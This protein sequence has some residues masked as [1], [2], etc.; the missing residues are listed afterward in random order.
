[1]PASSHGGRGLFDD[2]ILN[3]EVDIGLVCALVG[4]ICG[5]AGIAAIL[6]YAVPAC[7]AAAAR[8]AVAQ[9]AAS[10]MSSSLNAPL[11]AREG[12]SAAN[13]GAGAYPKAATDD[14]EHRG[15]ASLGASNL[16]ASNLGD[17]GYAGA[18][19]TGA[20]GSYAYLRA[21]AGSSASTATL[22]QSQDASFRAAEPSI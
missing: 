15:G 12:A 19:R 20:A 2:P 10:T 6:L 14:A 8:R 4:F 9:R 22:G 11:A 5:G 3:E 13:F 7:R 17:S 1:M 16:G 18:P 21:A